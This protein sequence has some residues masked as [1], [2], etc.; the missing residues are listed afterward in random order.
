MPAAYAQ[1]APSRNDV[2][3]AAVIAVAYCGY[4]GATAVAL[5]NDLVSSVWMLVVIW[6][7][8]APTRSR[9][10]PPR[11]TPPS[12]AHRRSTA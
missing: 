7:R 10:R 12:A 9:R 8:S 2:F 4:C 5:E 3:A 6:A 1:S 11:R